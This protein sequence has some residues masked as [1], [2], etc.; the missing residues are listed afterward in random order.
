M[1]LDNL[2]FAVEDSLGK[3]PLDLTLSVGL[4]PL[5]GGVSVVA[6]NVDLGHDRE[7]DVELFDDVEFDHRAFVWLLVAEL[8]AREGKDLEALGMVST[9]DLAI[10][11]VVLVGEASSTRDVDDNDGLCTR[12]K[13]AQFVV[14]F[15]SAAKASKL[16]R[17][18]SSV[19]MI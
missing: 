2:A 15:S 11:V 4:E 3:V 13:V 16:K 14:G 1:E 12:A 5:E 9:V 17:V 8:V 18:F 19:C 6:F 7:L 10:L